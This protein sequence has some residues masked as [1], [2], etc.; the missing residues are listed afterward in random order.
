MNIWYSMCDFKNEYRYWQKD[1]FIYWVNFQPNLMPVILHFITNFAILCLDI[2][3]ECF[4]TWT[5]K[6]SPSLWCHILGVYVSSIPCKTAWKFV[7]C[8]FVA[9]NACQIET[10]FAN[11]CT[12]LLCQWICEKWE[13]FT[14]LVHLIHGKCKPWV[15]WDIHNWQRRTCL[16]QISLI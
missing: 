9:M 6:H 2:P 4:L 14:L 1:K 16:L 8:L 10:L 5:K 11:F 3:S 12:L 7:C 15:E 13:V